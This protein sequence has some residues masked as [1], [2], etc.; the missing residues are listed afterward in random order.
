MSVSV[1]V[2]VVGLVARCV[3]LLI[4]RYVVKKYMTNAHTG[5]YMHYI[6]N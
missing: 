6:T 3:T 1:C 4:W 5:L 2:C